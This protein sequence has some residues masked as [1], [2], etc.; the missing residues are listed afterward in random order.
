MICHQISETKIDVTKILPHKLWWYLV[1]CHR[2]SWWQINLSEIDTIFLCQNLTLKNKLSAHFFQ[3]FLQAAQLSTTC[4]NTLPTAPLVHCAITVGLPNPTTS[5]TIL[6]QKFG[7]NL[8]P[9][10]VTGIF[11]DNLLPYSH[12]FN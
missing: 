10:F 1:I 9:T 8:P 3:E 5:P 6:S 4:S 7:D 12:Q 11:S 2:I